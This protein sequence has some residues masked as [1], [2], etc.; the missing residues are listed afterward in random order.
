MSAAA[1]ERAAPE[2][3]LPE[4][5]LPLY[6]IGELPCLVGSALCA[7]RVNIWKGTV[8]GKQLA[9]KRMAGPR[10]QQQQSQRAMGS[11]CRQRAPTHALLTTAIL[12]DEEARWR[13]CGTCRRRPLGDPPPAAAA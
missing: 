13:A 8:R 7:M 12:L 1:S 11:A 5:V 4:L 6:S 2:W 3:P 10:G 9:R